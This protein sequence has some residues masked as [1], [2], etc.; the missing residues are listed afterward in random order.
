MNWNIARMA[1]LRLAVIYLF[2]QFMVVLWVPE[3]VA[4]QRVL[5]VI[6]PLTASGYLA[7]AALRHMGSLRIFWLLVMLGLICE[8]LA[9][10][11]WAYPIWTK[12]EYLAELS[13]ADWLWTME[14]VL[15]TTGLVYLFGHEQGLLRGLRFMFDIVIIFIVF[16]TVS[17]EYLLKPQLQGYLLEGEGTL[18][19]VNLMYPVCGIILIFFT[20]VLYANAKQVQA[21]VAVYLCFGGLAFVIGNLFYLVTVDLVGAVPNPYL[22]LLWTTAVFLIG[23]AG[24]RSVSGMREK[25]I[26]KDKQPAFGTFLVKYLLPYGVLGWLFY[27]ITERFEG[28]SGLFTGLSLSVL[29]ILVRQVLIQLEN[30]RLMERLHVSLKQSE[31]LAHHDD[32]TGLYNRRYFNT[33][34]MESIEDAD[35]KGSRLGLLYMDLNQFKSVN[36]SYGHRTGDL[37]IQMVARRLCSLDSGRMIVSR[38]GGDE[39]T[40]MVYPAVDDRELAELA[41]QISALLSKPYE[42]EGVEIQTGASIGLAVYPDH[43]ANDQE[44]IGRA[45]SAMYAAKENGVDW[46]FYAQSSPTVSS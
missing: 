15:F 46:Q 30:D 28:W 35:Q 37:L 10:F 17:W 21:M 43:A 19:W 32:L 31:Y 33:Q 5:T 16:I 34:L 29:F 3:A 24:V 22:D 4:V 38:L 36:D 25:D 45:D 6:A 39:F 1:P 11:V 8:G 27:L 23:M 42:L 40:V 26:V 14:M 2:V 9:Q 13:A 41:D 7:L 20:L 44:L 12:G 18:L